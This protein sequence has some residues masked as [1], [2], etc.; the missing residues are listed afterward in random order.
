[1]I[2][3]E[4]WRLFTQAVEGRVEAMNIQEKAK[5]SESTAF[6]ALRFYWKV[7]MKVVTKGAAWER[8]V[9]GIV[10]LSLS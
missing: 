7:Y 5:K 1:M 6:L 9:H 8:K 3:G 2:K 10:K 4:K